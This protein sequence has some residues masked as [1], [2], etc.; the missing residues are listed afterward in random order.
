M[1]LIRINFDTSITSELIGYLPDLKYIQIEE[2]KKK[3][4]EK[5]EKERLKKLSEVAVKIESNL[6]TIFKILEIQ[7]NPINI[8]QKKEFIVTNLEDLLHLVLTQTNQYLNRLTEI[9]KTITMNEIHLERLKLIESGFKFLKKYNFSREKLE[10]F[11]QLQ[12][13][14]YTTFSKNVLMLENIIKFSEF[15]VLMQHEE[16]SDDR[17]AFFLIYPKEFDKEINQ[18]LTNIHA[19]EVILY[20][21]YLMKTSI[22]LT[23]FNREINQIENNLSKLVHEL[24]LIKKEDIVILYAFKEILENFQK[25]LFIENNLARIS[26]NFSLLKV[27]TPTKYK[28]E[29]I[30]KLKEQFENKIKLEAIN[31]KKNKYVDE[32]KEFY[33]SK[34]KPDKI[35]KKRKKE[36]KEIISD[37]SPKEEET[38]DLRENTPIVFQHNRFIRPFESLIKLYG[39]PNYSEIDPTFFL[40]FT[41]PLIFGFMFGDVGH[42]LVLIISG[43]IGRILLRKKDQDTKNF[44][45]IILYCGFGALFAGFFYGEFFGQEIII[46]GEVWR[47]FYNPM[48]NVMQ[49]LYLAIIIGIIQINLGWFI[50]AINYWKSKKK[51]LAISDS[52]FK[53]L[54]LIGGAILIFNWGFRITEWFAL[55]YPILLPLIPGLLLIVLKPIGKSLHIASYLKEESYGGLIGE[56][57]MEAFET[58]LSILSNVFSYARILALAMAHIG[59][60]FAIDAMANLIQPDNMLMEIVRIIGL[61]FGNMIVIVLETVIVFIHDLRLHFYEFFSKFYGGAGKLFIPFEITNNYYTINFTQKIK[62]DKLLKEIDKTKRK[63]DFSEIELEKK[64]IIEKFLDGKLE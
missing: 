4:E 47:L 46:N 15:P 19:E 5:L 53:I 21:R 8:E 10:I 14:C 52:F 9:E 34:V 24:N 64:K 22:N 2:I 60:M 59:L 18:K 11:N 56:G 27:F 26:E 57:S 23:Q 41:F 13:R 20:K 49:I 45:I 48:E 39:A 42:G 61:I 36:K 43:I 55:P 6:K 29:I 50:Q 32:N 3:E 17:T 40:A 25:Y 63:I 28:Q 37:I 30:N 16:I 33:E 58:L 1:S 12:F 35:T 54:L 7:G 51:F 44:C 38:E 62:E 31:I